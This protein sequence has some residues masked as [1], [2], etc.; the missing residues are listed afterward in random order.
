M[1][2]VVEAPDGVGNLLVLL[3]VRGQ[4]SPDDAAWFDDVRL[5]ALD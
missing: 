1:F 4:A 2:G 5:Y 3:C